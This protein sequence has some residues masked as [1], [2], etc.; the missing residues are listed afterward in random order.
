MILS[1][2][3]YLSEVKSLLGADYEYWSEVDDDIK[4]SKLI[5]QL[6]Y[7]WKKNPDNLLLNRVDLQD[8]L[9]VD[10]LKQTITNLKK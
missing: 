5:E 4:I 6:Y 2:S 9:S 7:L 8:Y 10:N 3:P 1:L